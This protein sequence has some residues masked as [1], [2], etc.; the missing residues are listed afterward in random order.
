MEKIGIA[1][2]A[3]G[4]RGLAHILM[5]ETLDE[6]GLKPAYVSGASVGAIAGVLYCSGMTGKELRELFSELTASERN[7]VKNVFNLKWLDFIMPQFDGAG[8]LKAENFINFLFGSISART[9]EELDIP[10]FVVA[11]NFWTREE[12]IL[13]SG[14]LV[15]ALQASM[16]LPGI[17]APVL[18]GDQVL[19]DGGAVNPVPFDILPDDCD[20]TIAID[21]IGHRTAG[22]GLMPSL[23][24]A[25][26]NT[27]QIME[28]S[29][30]REKLRAARPDIYI[31]P[32]ISD[33][34]VLEFYKAEHVFRQ[35]QPAKDQLKRELEK[36]LKYS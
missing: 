22:S 14:E 28:K 19:I 30:T 23:R 36:R 4:A 25:I 24:D 27:F 15:S 8:L 7:S 26:F 6:L 16:S 33:V 29:I 32:D 5:L 31:A 10:L 1:L 12:I 2:G 17:F 20:L 9:F 21:V 3:G 18:M 11:A 35:A 34:R 13:K